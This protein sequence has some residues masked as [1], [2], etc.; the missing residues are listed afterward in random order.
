[1]YF[2]K[3]L[4]WGQRRIEKGA[5][6]FA[7]LSMGYA[8]AVWVRN[9]LYDRKW[10]AITRVPATVIS[11]G[12]IVAGGSGKTPLVLLL[13][14]MFPQKNIAILSRG[15]GGMA[16]EAQ[17]FARRLPHAKVYVG[18]NRVLLAKQAV[19]EG[20]EI[21]LLDDGFQYR[22]LH[23][24]FD[25]VLLAE[26]RHFLPWGFLRDHPKRLKKADL[27]I[28][29][30]AE[31]EFTYKVDRI[32]N[33]KGEV[34]PTI[35][36]KKAALFCGIAKPLAFRKMVQDLGV[37]IV[38]ELFLADHEPIFKKKLNDLASQ[39]DLI[40]CT[41]KDAVKLPLTDLPVYFLEISLEITRGQQRWQEF[42][43]VLNLSKV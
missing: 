37:E 1:M 2:P 31:V 14:K 23:R 6:Y 19:K 21:V 20:A 17:I 8:L 28:G 29:P 10:L 5:W 33:I 39:A 3:L 24:D 35:C 38:Q 30:S 4:K 41:E 27:L 22:R 9:F 18:K 12:N 32:V 34:L 26:G 7:P 11:V 15:Y 36:G 16:D 42:I 25:L 13:A 40:L 43:S